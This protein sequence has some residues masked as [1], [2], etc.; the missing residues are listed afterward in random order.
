M[1]I[2]GRITMIG[3]TNLDYRSIEYNLELSTIIRSEEFG[4]QMSALFRNDVNFA[5]R[6][7]L[8]EWRKRT[9]TD[10]FIQWMVSRARYLL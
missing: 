6:I 4:R 3:S 10:R 9:L 1:T 8:K 7:N 5:K 2:D